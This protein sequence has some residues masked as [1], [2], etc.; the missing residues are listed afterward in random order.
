MF[1]PFS[2]PMVLDLFSDLFVEIRDSR[3]CR[4]IL[5]DFI[6]FIN[7]S[8]C[9]SGEGVEGFGDSAGRNVKFGSFLKGVSKENFSFMDASNISSMPK[10]VFNVFLESRP[11]SFRKVNK[12]NIFCI[13]LFEVSSH[14]DNDGEMVRAHLISDPPGGGGDEIRGDNTNVRSS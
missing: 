13:K 10:F 12:S 3:V 11:V 1:L 14:V 5:P 9:F 7:Q 8:G 4:I 6:P 2:F